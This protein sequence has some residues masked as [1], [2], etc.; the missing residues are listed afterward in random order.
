MHNRNYISNGLLIFIFFLSYYLLTFGR[1]QEYS[2]FDGSI[3]FNVTKSIVEDGS[4]KSRVPGIYRGG[5]EVVHS[6]YGLGFSIVTIPMYLLLKF[7]AQQ[8]GIFQF[9]SI[10]R[11][12]PMLTN[13]LITALTC[14][15][16]FSFGNQ[17]FRNKRIAFFITAIYGLATMAWPY[18]RYDFSEPLAGL[19][20]F[21]AIYTLFLFQQG[22]QNYWL[23]ISSL[24]ISFALFTR[25]VEVIS[26]PFWFLYLYQL[27][28]E[29][30]ATV[31]KRFFIQIFL[32][33]IL[34]GI[35]YFWYNYYRYGNIFTTG[36]G[37]DLRI[38]TLVRN[39]L[40]GLY[41]LLL[42][43][44]KGLFWYNPPL[45]LFL[46]SIPIVY[47]RDR[48]LFYCANGIILA[49]LVTYSAWTAW[50]GGWCW[51]PR[52]LLP[53]LPW[54]VLLSGYW[55]ETRRIQMLSWFLF[56]CGFI[57]QFLGIVFPYNHY[58]YS[59]LSN[60]IPFS[61]LLFQVQH[62]PILGHLILLFQYPMYLWDFALVA[63]V[64]DSIRYYKLG[65]I[66]ILVFIFISSTVILTKRVINPYEN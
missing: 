55:L 6:Q 49:H 14:T 10:A 8:T 33:L 32:P 34:T 44:G 2:Y 35:A 22:K 36:Y 65:A 41:G 7:I 59:T 24:A 54:L 45:L 58:I 20:I 50:E 26:L 52:L 5:V 15:L 27:L 60:G 53:I 47:N 3:M 13:V 38:Q 23:V 28:K 21:G 66:V 46:T 18:S 43:P 37:L 39:F 1:S 56:L 48:S 29:K 16:L 51:G 40:P 25:I 31:S 9:E 19:C 63:T 4:L 12:A 11:A 57:I 42:S 30:K 62:S 61:A 64:P 17:L